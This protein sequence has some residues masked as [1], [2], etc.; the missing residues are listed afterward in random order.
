M[1]LYISVCAGATIYTGEALK[2]RFLYFVMHFL[3]DSVDLLFVS[4]HLCQTHL[5]ILQIVVKELLYKNIE[6]IFN[7]VKNLVTCL[8][9]SKNEHVSFCFINTQSLYI[10]YLLIYNFALLF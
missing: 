9:N 5:F 8:F 6:Y 2:Y 7:I 10:K 4:C 1:H 3:A